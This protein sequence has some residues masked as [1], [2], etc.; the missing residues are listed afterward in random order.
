[1]RLFTSILATVAM[2]AMAPSAFAAITY[3][4]T[5]TTSDSSPLSAVTVGAQI[6]IDITVRTDDFASAA[7]GS[8]NNYDNSVVALNA[9]ASTIAGTI[10][11]QI[12]VAPGTCFNGLTNQSGSAIPFAETTV[13]TVGVESQFLNALGLAPAGGNGSVDE[14]AVGGVTGDAQFQIVFDASAG[15]STTLNIG[16]YFAYQDGYTGTDGLDPGTSTNTSIAIT[17]IPEPGTA[18]L[19]GLGLAGLAG[20]GR[21]K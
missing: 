17:V 11:N 10:F 19:M 14:G 16:T 6:I 7:G 18:L 5:A 9:G 2:L 8:V 3:T 20:A 1:M 21:R 13:G 15:G 4:A 12:C